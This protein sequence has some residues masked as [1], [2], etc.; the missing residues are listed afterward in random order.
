MPEEKK[1]I[2]AVP[3]QV[4]Y[5]DEIL[6]CFVFFSPRRSRQLEIKQNGDVIV[7]MPDYADMENVRDFVTE[8]G[9]WILK[10]RKVFV[11]RTMPKRRYETGD[12]M[13]F[14]GRE[15]TIER[16][17][18]AARA[19]I[20]G[21]VLEIY[22]PEGFEGDEA[23]DLARDVVIL[24]YRRLGL[25]V[26]DAFVEKYAA[27]EGVEKPPVRIKLQ[28]K[29]WGS[30]TPKNGITINARVLLAPKIVAEYLV[31]HEVVHL[32]LRHHQA[33]YWDEVG[34]VMPEYKEAERLLKEEGWGYIF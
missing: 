22:L 34:R 29:R 10:H 28:E 26:L 11:A 5:K 17:T 13:P 32:R 24:L 27:L 9:D 19:Q 7:R 2:K 12:T 14:F 1:L 16:K 23:S 20:A 21:D 33:S 18:G 30:C 25:K 6:P 8:K 4:T 15:L 3:V 31:A